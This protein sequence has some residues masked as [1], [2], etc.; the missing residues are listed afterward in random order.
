MTLI[1]INTDKTGCFYLKSTC[2]LQPANNF[3]PTCGSIL[4]HDRFDGRD[5]FAGDAREQEIGT[6]PSPPFAEQKEQL[7]AVASAR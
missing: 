7:H 3:R 5:G 4:G 2:K 1:R 6:S